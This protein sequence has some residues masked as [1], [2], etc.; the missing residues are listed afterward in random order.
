MWLAACCDAA[1]RILAVF[2]KRSA[3]NHDI[4]GH[5][6][7]VNDGDGCFAEAIGK[8]RGEKLLF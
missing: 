7:T 1:V 6:M 4:Q 8:L 3:A 5:P 2:R